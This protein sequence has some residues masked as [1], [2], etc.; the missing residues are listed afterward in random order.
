MI[1]SCQTARFKQLKQAEQPSP[2]MSQSGPSEELPDVARTF[3]KLLAC[4]LLAAWPTSR[5]PATGWVYSWRPTHFLW[6]NCGLPEVVD[7][8]TKT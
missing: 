2:S 4:R 5:R 3:A 6:S 7:K 8:V 1:G